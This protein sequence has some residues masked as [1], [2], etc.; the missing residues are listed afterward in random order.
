[1]LV[2]AMLGVVMVPRSASASSCSGGSD[3]SSSFDDSATS[4]SSYDSPSEPCDE[5]CTQYNA[6]RAQNMPPVKLEI[7]FLSRSFTN[8][9][10]S[11]TGSVTHD[12]TSYAFRA[13]M[14]TGQ[15]DAMDNAYG[16]LLRLTGKLGA[17][18]YTGGELEI[19]GVETSAA[20]IEMSASGY[21]PTVTQGTAIMVGANA[22]L[23]VGG[24]LTDHIELGFEAAGGVRGIGYSFDSQLGACESSAT[25]WEAQG[26]LEARARGT[27]WLSDHMN[28]TAF[29]GRSFLDDGMVGGIS[30]GLTNQPL[31]L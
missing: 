24:H 9:F 23:G 5:A 17:G 8:P 12:D 10:G 27:L 14:P 7:G 20:S 31:G 18:F 13:T 21:G 26:V 1:M 28:V 3:T 19:A 22:V 30:F 6:W 4:T 29:G 25:M 11:R 16:G 2:A 15:S